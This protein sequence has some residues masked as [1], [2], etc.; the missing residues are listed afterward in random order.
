MDQE[1]LTIIYGAVHV[2]G[3]E[4]NRNIEAFSRHYNMA[5]L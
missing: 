3:V 2:L 5:T 4:I 1:V